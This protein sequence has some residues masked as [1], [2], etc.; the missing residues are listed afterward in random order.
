MTDITPIRYDSYTSIDVKMPLLT[1]ATYSIDVTNSTG[2][3]STTFPVVSLKQSG[4]N[5]TPTSAIG[6]N[7]PTSATLS[8]LDEPFAEPYAT[9]SETFTKQGTD[10]PVSS[11]SVSAQQGLGYVSNS[12]IGRG[13]LWA[14]NQ[15]SPSNVPQLSAYV[16]L[17][18][19]IPFNKSTTN[20][21][22]V[23]F[24]YKPHPEKP[25]QL[26]NS[27]VSLVNS[28]DPYYSHT[29]NLT[30]RPH[31]FVLQSQLSSNTFYKYSINDYRMRD[32]N[33]LSSFKE[34]DPNKWYHIFAYI[35]AP[36]FEQGLFVDGISGRDASPTP[37]DDSYKF[38]ELPADNVFNIGLKLTSTG[39]PIERVTEYPMLGEICNLYWST[40]PLFKNEVNAYLNQS[41]TKRFFERP[42]FTIKET[43]TKPAVVFDNCVI[44]NASPTGAETL[45]VDASGGQDSTNQVVDFSGSKFSGFSFWYKPTSIPYSEILHLQKFNSYWRTELKIHLSQSKLRVTAKS[46]TNNTLAAGISTTSVTPGVWYHIVMFHDRTNPN[47]LTL[48]R[49]FINGVEDTVITDIL[50]DDGPLYTYNTSASLEIIK[51]SPSSEGSISDIY[52]SSKPDFANHVNAYYTNTDIPTSSYD[53]LIK[54]GGK[55]DDAVLDNWK[56]G[57]PQIDGVIGKGS[58]PVSATGPG[59]TV[60]PYLDF[61]NKLPLGFVLGSPSL[62]YSSSVETFIGI[63]F[64][65]KLK[66]DIP[67]QSMFYMNDPSITNDSIKI[68]SWSA[69]GPW[70]DRYLGFQVNQNGLYV[71]AW[72]DVQGTI[73]LHKWHHLFCYHEI[74]SVATSPQIYIDGVLQSTSETYET[75]NILETIPNCTKGYLHAWGYNPAEDRPAMGYSGTAISNLYISNNPNFKNKLADYSN[76]PTGEMT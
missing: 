34:L 50:Y 7:L 42:N 48:P 70:S 72:T 40:N 51:G 39:F 52:I 37:P 47:T 19:K 4:L 18:S 41:P 25:G 30:H 59:D 23:S 29:M 45:T 65:F 1:E 12:L 15:V 22:G 27:L 55:N 5:V 10:S 28:L 3:G 26:G 17:S 69:G 8:I 21:F 14:Q 13:G 56:N 38:F 33:E 6:K 73:E 49:L 62:G 20:F 35:D 74:T 63:S 46:T 71:Q 64:W 44:N 11:W 53:E 68:D 9:G 36:N 58:E 67:A 60:F 43:F 32:P 76:K 16:D 54:F 61:S 31:G 66:E 75:S 2:V 57:L 24:W